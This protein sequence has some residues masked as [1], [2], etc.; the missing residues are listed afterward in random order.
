[1]NA[2]HRIYLTLDELTDTPALLSGRDGYPSN[3]NVAVLGE[4]PI[5]SDPQ[6][7]LILGAEADGFLRQDLLN[8]VLECQQ[9][10]KKHNQTFEV[11]LAPLNVIQVVHQ[12][13]QTIEIARKQQ[14]EI[15]SAFE[16]LLAESFRMKA[17]DIHI[18]VRRLE[19]VVRYRIDGEL[20]KATNWPR[21]FAYRFCQV[22]YSV[23]AEE[24]GKDVTFRPD[25]PQ[26]AIIDKYVDGERVRVRLGTVP[27]APDGFDM[28]MRLL[29]LGRN[30]SQK[31]VPL[32]TLGY[33]DEQVR[34]IVAGASKPVG[35]TIIAGTTGS[36][37]STTLKNILQEKIE[38]SNGTIK[39][40]T[41]EDP[42]E[43]YIP[44]ATQVPVS[45]NRKSSDGASSFEAAIRGAMRMDPDILMV[46]EVR[47]LVTAKLLISAVQSGHQA[48]TTV[49]AP[50][51]LS[52]VSRLAS[53]GVEHEILGSTDFIASLI[54]QSL[55]PLLC[56]TCRVSI[57]QVEKDLS[58]YHVTPDLLDR[59]RFVAPN[60][61]DRIYFRDYD[62]CNNCRYGIK[63]R[64]VVA[65][66]VLP[67]HALLK[68]FARGQS[69]DA[70]EHWLSHGGKPILQHGIEKMVAGLVS[71]VD[72]EDALG[73]L[74]SLLIMRDGVFD[75]A[76]EMDLLPTQIQRK[77]AVNT[78]FDSEVDAESLLDEGID[79]HDEE[80]A[81]SS[82]LLN[83]MI[84]Q[85]AASFSK[86][87]ADQG[88]E[89]RDASPL[90]GGTVGALDVDK[91]A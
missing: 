39:V 16:D 82:A 59:I 15:I 75:H 48:F 7:V 21:A 30:D 34:M 70:L 36:G 20:M 27:A 47:D 31:S 10:A 84:D 35:A 17:S 25:T 51:A 1:M 60:D 54:Y 45:R 5:A 55:L 72:V 42:A 33:S 2:E 26:D 12:R 64:T 78:D 8:V 41:V 62:G 44:G 80:W 53:M 3:K 50:S 14:S 9:V 58:R 38:K 86:E 87:S 11:G 43:Y 56:P 74:S 68:L 61:L 40:I 76:K 49:H 73:P 19:A 46:G 23:V 52:I 67:D 83:S 85:A 69:V 29:P 81:E 65:E 32:L 71:P 63:G 24:E 89:P 57:S 37:K 18:E 79:I 13:E 90:E 66:V 77:Q 88:S 4:T 91:G 28:A 6:R 22:V